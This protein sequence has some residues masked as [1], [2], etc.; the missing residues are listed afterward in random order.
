M[1]LRRKTLL[2]L[3]ISSMVLMS[4]EIN[5][6][7]EFFQTSQVS[8]ILSA[9]VP[10]TMVVGESYSLGITYQKDS[11]CH[12]FSNF[13]G[14]SQGDSIVFVRAITLFTQAPNCSQDASEE[15]IEFEFTNTF[16]SD[17]TFK[18]LQDIDSEG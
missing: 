9:N 4:C 12:T 5:D 14:T 10:D 7:D 6:D 8:P 16:Q 3:F 17:F 2:G 1:K 11:N 15:L 18:F 13:N